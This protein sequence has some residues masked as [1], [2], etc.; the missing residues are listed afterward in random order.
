MVRG[1][2]YV[3]SMDR[4]GMHAAGLR[5]TSDKKQRLRSRYMRLE[6]QLFRLGDE[7]ADVARQEELVEAELSYH[8]LIADDAQRDAA[9]G[10]DKLE[11]GLTANDV[12]RFE[13][14][15]GALRQRR[16]KLESKR[17]RLMERL[18]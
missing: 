9:L 15:L 12:R 13:R 4:H 10:I 8:R 18:G 5:D 6:K 2:V 3:R 14:A 16:E 7:I 1:P 17:S 11:A